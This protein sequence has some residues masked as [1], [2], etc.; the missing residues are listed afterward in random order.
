M[1]RFLA[2]TLALWFNGVVFT[3]GQHTAFD[4]FVSKISSQYKVD[5]ALSPELIPTVDSILDSGTA[6]TSMDALLHLLMYKDVTYQIIDGNKLMLRKDLQS[7][8]PDGSY[9]IKGMILDEKDRTPLPFAIVRVVNSSKGCQTDEW[10]HFVLPVQDTNGMIEVDYLGYTAVQIPIKDFL[11]G[12][13]TV[14]MAL[15]EI[16]L[17]EVTIIIPYKEINQ[18]PT[19]QA[20]NL[21]YYKLITEDQLLQWNVDRLINTLTSYTQFSNEEGIRI[22]GVEPGN[23]LFLMDGLPVHDPYHF[24]NIFSPFNTHYFSSIRLYKNNL[25]VEY[26]GRIDGMIRLESDQRHEDSRLILDADLLRTS[27]A[28]TIKVSPAFS[29]FGGARY[30][31]TGML[32]DALRDT[33]TDSNTQSLGRLR[34]ENEWTSVQEPHFNFYDINAGLSGRMG[35]TNL[36]ANFFNS[37]DELTKT[38]V[39]HISTTVNE[40]EVKTIDQVFINE[41]K[42]RNI[43]VSAGMVSPL[44]ND[45]ALSLTGFIAEYERNESYSRD[46]EEH[47]FNN[48]KKRYNVGFNDSRLT[49]IGLKA[50]Y[51]KDLPGN[52]TYQ[53]GLDL[54]RYDVGLEAKENGEA[55]VTQAQRELESTLFGEYQF[56]PL[57]K[58]TVVSGARFTHLQDPSHVYVLPNL[59]INQL[60]GERFNVRAA[61]SK[62][63]QAV[64][65]LTIENRF[66]REMESL[67]LNSSAKDYPVL[68]SDK[69]MAGTGFTSKHFNLDAEFFYKKLDGLMRVSSPEPDPGFDNNSPPHNFYRLYVGKGWTR[70]MDI[71]AYYKKGKTDIL[72]SYTLSKMVEQYDGL[73]KSEEFSP[74]EDR[75]HQ[76][77]FSAKQQIGKFDLRSLL[78]YKSKAPYLSL[79]KLENNDWDHGGHGH[80][81]TEE[82]EYELVVDY[83]DPFFS[84]DLGI[85][86][87]FK[88]S[89]QSVQVGISLLNATDHKNIEEVQYTGRVDNEG[90]NKPLYISDQTELLGRTWNAHFKIV[91]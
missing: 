85:D 18:D 10:G 70:G 39:T 90:M 61:Y 62:S 75:R 27:V 34:S 6:I 36:F 13:I 57:Q 43:G 25:P 79:V 11:N 71:T 50:I 86:Y 55:F 74:Q 24:Y 33:E 3:F 60:I 41:D 8:H 54:N 20:F 46:F 40:H 91:F 26:G 81:H 68:K 12:P 47:A 83:L 58:L 72:A 52:N 37:M 23:S 66:S 51:S 38:T 16:P 77:K 15:R 14:N 28:A 56:K 4:S 42:W 21:E 7:D 29:V 35:N 17:E 73:Y 30:S 88:L 89:K 1:N 59:R 19:S 44:S 45:A 22:R 69:Y 78:T 84:L 80:G 5:I 53:F 2:I 48:Y 32:N 9:K 87:S 65:E 67:V 49:T 64:H 82:A 31:Y 76:V 63:V